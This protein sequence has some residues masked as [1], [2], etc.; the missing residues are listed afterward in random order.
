MQGIREFQTREPRSPKI[1]SLITCL[2]AATFYSLVTPTHDFF[3]VHVSLTPCSYTPKF[4]N[5]ATCVFPIAFLLLSFR[6]ASPHPVS[7]SS[8][9]SFPRPITVHSPLH[10]TH[11]S[12]CVFSRQDSNGKICGFPCPVATESARASPDLNEAVIAAVD[13][14]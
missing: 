8:V 1:R 5:F 7:A 10:V 13:G 11:Q 14:G 3:P 4:M 9:S 2:L 12:Y 6:A